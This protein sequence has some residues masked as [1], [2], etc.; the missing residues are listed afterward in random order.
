VL[1]APQ[2]GLIEDNDNRNE[3]A[4]LSRWSTTNSSEGSLTSLDEYVQRMPEDQKQIF[5]V[6]GETKRQALSSPALEM[7][8]KKGYEVIFLMDPLD[9]MAMQSLGKFQ[10]KDIVDAAK[11]QMAETD[12][13]KSFLEEKGKELEKLR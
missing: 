3:L 1:R 13:E 8:R 10:D 11:E 2:V 7:L 5:Y 12:E 4:K 6:T 9:E